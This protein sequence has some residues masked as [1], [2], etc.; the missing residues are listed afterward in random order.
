[1]LFLLPSLP[2][3]G[4]T[5]VLLFNMTMPITLWAMTKIMPGA[6]GFAFGLLS[7]GLFLGFL[8]KYLGFT[9]SS[10]MPLVFALLTAGSL[11]LMLLGLRR[12]IS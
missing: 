7:F 3:A 9:V 12:I 1:L 6:K 10:K 5:A 4:V 11:V 2:L 8:P